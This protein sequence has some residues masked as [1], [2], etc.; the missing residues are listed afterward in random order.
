[1]IFLDLIICDYITSNK[2]L[3]RHLAE[4][5]SATSFVPACKLYVLSF[6]TSPIASRIVANVSKIIFPY[7]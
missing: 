5:S 3:F 4:E 2:L 1:M 7:A 6:E